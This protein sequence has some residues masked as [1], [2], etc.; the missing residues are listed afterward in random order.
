MNVTI[1]LSELGE[2]TI[3]K[4]GCGH[5][6]QVRKRRGYAGEYSLDVTSLAEAILSYSDISAHDPES[7]EVDFYGD[8]DYHPRQ[9]GEEAL[10][11]ALAHLSEFEVGP[12][13]DLP[14]RPSTEDPWLQGY[15]AA[16]RVVRQRLES[17]FD[18]FDQFEA[19]KDF[20]GPPHLTPEL[21]RGVIRLTFSDLGFP[22]IS[23]GLGGA[24]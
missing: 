13:V 4:T 20:E 17:L 24:R 22:P 15:N 8:V 14:E 18:Q 19:P 21:V 9:G 3:H 2:P 5:L 1:T 6:A 11:E 16:L 23:E 12:C 10:E 7:T